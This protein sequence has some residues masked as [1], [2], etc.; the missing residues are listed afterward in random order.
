MAIAGFIIMALGVLLILLGAYVSMKDWER[1]Q[2]AEAARGAEAL[3]LD[4]TIGALEKL[5]DALK[6]HQLGMQLILV[7]IVV[8]LVGGVI[9]TLSAV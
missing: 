1:K 2:Q 6:G 7:G 4:K 5:A 9:G 3:S 8:I